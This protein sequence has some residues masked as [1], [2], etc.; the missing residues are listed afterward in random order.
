MN[1]PT[2]HLAPIVLRRLATAAAA[3][4]LWAHPARAQDR[5]SIDLRVT[6]GET[7]A[8][9]PGASVRLNGVSAGVSD[10]R[11][12]LRLL[13]SGAGTHQLEVSMLGRRTVSPQLELAPGRALNLEV[14]L[15]PEEV[16]LPAMQ[17]IARSR[18]PGDG[19]MDTGGLGGVND[20]ALLA[21]LGTHAQA[22][23][24]L[25][26]PVRDPVIPQVRGRVLAD[27]NADAGSEGSAGVCVPDLFVDGV[28]VEYNGAVYLGDLAQAEPD[29]RDG[30]PEFGNV[31]SECGAILIWTTDR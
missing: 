14:V 3:A 24:E 10:A 11:G 19:S 7:G 18:G 27:P 6:D 8:S 20:K 9:L 28:S 2:L 29:P 23:S 12:A 26:A 22:V 31:T 21:A 25:S 30:P 15:E 4:L 13:A 1:A 16:R 17:V 5:A